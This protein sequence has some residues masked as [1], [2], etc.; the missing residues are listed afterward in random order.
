[1]NRYYNPVHT[2][3][4]P[5]CLA[6]LPALLRQMLP[7]G[8]RTLVLAWSREALRHPVLAGLAASCAPIEVESLE[9]TAS[10]PTVEQ[11]YDTWLRT[12]DHAPNVVVAVGGGSILDVGKIALLPVWRGA[13]RCGRAARQRRSRG[14]AAGGPLDRRAHHR[15]HWQ[16]GDLLGYHLGPEQDTKR[17][18]ENHDN[19]AAA[20][21]VDPEMAAGMPVRLAVS[22]AL[23]AVAHAVESYWARHTNAVSRALALEAIR[24][25]MGSI[26]QLFAGVPAAHDAMAR[27]SMLAGLAFSNTKTTACH[28]I[29]Y[30]LT[31]HYGIPHGA[32]V[33]MLLAPVLACNAPAMQDLDALLDALGVS[34]AAGLQRR[35]TG[36]L[37]RSAQPA[38]LEGWGVARSDLAHLAGL[39]ITKGRA[40][41]NPVE[42]TPALIE[43]MLESIYRW[44]QSP[45]RADAQ[46]H[47]WKY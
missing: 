29:S 13:G 10:N 47:R 30:P 8:G 39:G 28:S 15:R 12:K 31:M 37:V 46:R 21:L 41:N 44:P 20:A 42:L 32:A 17:S 14:S 11:L 43:E 35:I 3:Q 26:D 4:G 36:L 16:R 9:F 34:D 6:E 24:T 23:D 33:A 40:D 27:G 45:V 22:S 18:L 5:G 1:M 2:I 38:S 19:Y 25:V 7:G